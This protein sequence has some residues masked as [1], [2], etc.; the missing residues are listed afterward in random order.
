[1]ERSHKAA[2]VRRNRQGMKI[3]TRCKKNRAARGKKLC[4][5]CG[6]FAG[7]A[8]KNAQAHRKQMAGGGSK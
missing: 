4:D 3:C 1:M 6:F 5:G 2:D 7:H 8:L